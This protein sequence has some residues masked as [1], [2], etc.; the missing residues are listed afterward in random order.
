VVLENAALKLSFNRNLR[1]SK[2]NMLQ[3]ML[4]N[5]LEHPGRMKFTASCFVE[6]LI[7]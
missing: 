6:E 2:E 5:G 4:L 1:F 7:S 3:I